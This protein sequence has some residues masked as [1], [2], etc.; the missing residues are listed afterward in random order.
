MTAGVWGRGGTFNQPAALCNIKI[1]ISKPVDNFGCIQRRKCI[2]FLGSNRECVGALW[3][4]DDSQLTTCA[5]RFACWCYLPS[6]S[7][8]IVTC[9]S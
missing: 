2:K 8:A 1:V 5:F 6:S 3:D 7:L 9:T 4:L